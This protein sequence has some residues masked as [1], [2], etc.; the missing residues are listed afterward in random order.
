MKKTFKL[1][2]LILITSCGNQTELK[3]QIQQLKIQNDSL[4]SELKNYENKYVF[5]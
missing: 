1:L 4:K 2:L 5:D 3:K